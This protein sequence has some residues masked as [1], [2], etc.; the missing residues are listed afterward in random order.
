MQGWASHCKGGPAYV[1]GGPVTNAVMTAFSKLF[2]K[3]WPG[4]AHLIF[5]GGPAINRVMTAFVSPLAHL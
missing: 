3:W 1:D 4:L 5:R 2:N